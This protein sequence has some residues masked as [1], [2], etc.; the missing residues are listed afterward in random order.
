[1]LVRTT[2]TTTGHGP[3]ALAVDGKTS[4]FTHRARLVIGQLAVARTGNVYPA[5]NTLRLS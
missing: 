2:L 5:P 4:V 3:L 1:M